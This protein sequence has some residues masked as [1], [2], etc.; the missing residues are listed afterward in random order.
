MAISTKDE[1]NPD[2]NPSPKMG[3]IF[4]KEPKYVE[5]DCVTALKE[6]ILLH[7]QHWIENN[8][9]NGSYLVGHS[10]WNV[11]CEQQTHFRSSLLSLPPKNSYFNLERSDDR[12]SVCCSQAIWNVTLAKKKTSNRKYQ[13]FHDPNIFV[14][15][16]KCKNA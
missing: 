16:L 2:M 9:L 14:P 12:K 11:A 13:P 3:K 10:L 15:F 7:F 6:I 5:R 8:I 1:L 4:L